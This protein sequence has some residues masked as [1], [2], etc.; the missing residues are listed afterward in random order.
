MISRN[1]LKYNDHKEIITTEASGRLWKIGQEYYLHNTSDN[2][3]HKNRQALFW[4]YVYYRIDPDLLIY[5]LYFLMLSLLVVFVKLF[6]CRT[7]F[8]K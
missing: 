2:L 3:D 4:T 8:L 5:Y 1:A 6:G 7:L